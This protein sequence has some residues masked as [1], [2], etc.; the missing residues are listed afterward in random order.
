MEGIFLFILVNAFK[1]VSG[2]LTNQ[3]LD[4]MDVSLA[5]SEYFE[6]SI[7]VV[8]YNFYLFWKTAARQFFFKTILLC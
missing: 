6:Y 4:F 7:Q 1:R 8:G 3:D 5:V 2:I